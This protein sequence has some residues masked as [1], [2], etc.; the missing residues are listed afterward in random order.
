MR[1]EP[2][3]AEAGM[4]L[5][6]RSVI[7]GSFSADGWGCVPFLL[8]VWYGVSCSGACWSLSGAGS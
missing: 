3:A 2:A 1:D 4:T 6:E 7:L 8:A 5:C